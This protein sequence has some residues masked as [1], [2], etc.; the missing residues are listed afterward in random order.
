MAPRTLSSRGVLRR[1]CQRY[2]AEALVPVVGLEIEWYPTRLLPGP[3]SGSVGTYALLDPWVEEYVCR[4]LGLTAEPAPSQVVAHDRHAELVAAVALLGGC[5][6]QI[7]LELRLLKRS[8][9][10]EMEKH[11][12][13]AYQGSSA[14]P[15]K[16]NPTTSERLCGLARLLRG[17]ATAMLEDVA[18]WHERDL[19]HSSVERVALVDSLL[20]GHYQ[21][22]AA[23]DLIETL[24]VF[25]E[26]MRA[27]LAL[28]GGTI[29]SSAVLVDLLERGMERERAYRAVQTAASEAA[30][31]DRDLWTALGGQGIGVRPVGPERFLVHHKVARERL[32]ALHG[33][34]D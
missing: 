27:N 9:A 31:G 16:R 20:V 34:E 6:E 22:S 24:T 23:A 15:H 32:E 2:A 25:P 30:A 3:I 18:L 10:A 1:V 21:A 29:Y 19:S 14:M 11:R 12:S 33:L 7:A 4:E 5:V 8:E 28:G 17:Y 13:V 26:R